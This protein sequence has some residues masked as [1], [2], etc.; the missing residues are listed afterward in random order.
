[1]SKRIVILFAG[2]F[3][4]LLNLPQVSFGM[5]RRY[6][7]PSS[8]VS[9]SGHNAYC[10]SATASA[11]TLT[12]DQCISGNSGG[13]IS[14]AS[15][16][17][18][19]YYNT[20]GDTIV[21]TS[22]A[23][24]S[25][26]SFI[27]ASS[28]TG[29]LTYTPA[30][31][32]AGTFY[33]FV[34]V[35][36]APGRCNTLYISTPRT[37]TVGSSGPGAIIGTNKLCSGT[38]AF[39]FNNMG[40]G[41]WSSGNTSIATINSTTGE[42]TGISAGTAQ[43]TYTTSCGTATYQVTVIPSPTITGAG[44]LCLNG[45]SITLTG[46]PSGG[47]WNSSDPSKATVDANG[48]LSGLTKGTSVISYT[49][50]SGCLAS[51]TIMADTMPK[52]IIIA[53]T[54]ICV[55]ESAYVFNEIYPGTWTTSNPNIAYF[56]VYNDLVGANEGAVNI[57]YSTSCGTVS[58]LVIIDSLPKPVITPDYTDNSLLTA[59]FYKYYQWYIGARFTSAT[60]IFNANTYKLIRPTLNDMFIVEV[61]DAKGCRGHSS[62]Y[63]Y[64]LGVNNIEHRQTA[65]IY[66]NPVSDVIKISSEIPV[67]AVIMN[68]KGETV[69]KQHN[70]HEINVHSLPSGMYTISLYSDNAQLVL[71]QTIVKN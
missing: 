58:Q 7:A 63:R 37:I 9:F 40:G 35:T 18:Q 69:L 64:T 61:T 67:D 56:D 1:M 31:S 60:Q 53:D 25:P 47:I 27:S 48:V 23:Y 57:S 36:I 71:Q 17:A 13:A 30:T 19:W 33:Y 15:C 34:R 51:K 10:T 65:K 4:I 54:S 26:F 28:N 62:P 11:D 22:T 45:P 5:V 55:G 44:T 46:T 49:I 24:G 38:R 39:L 43:I 32:A 21:A 6:A 12:Y 14:G 42:W 16:T 3:I 8:T 29:K 50:A 59:S 2:I 20:T 70:V 52:P 41:T 66:P 68:I